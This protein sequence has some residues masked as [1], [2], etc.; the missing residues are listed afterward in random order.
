[1]RALVEQGRIEIRVWDGGGVVPMEPA[2]F[3]QM[4]NIAAL[5]IV[6]GAALMADG[7]VGVGGPVGAVV[8]T[9][10]AVVPS[11][12]GVDLGCG[13]LAVQTDLL[14][15]DLEGYLPAIRA[16]LED[17]IPVGGPGVR[18]SWAE[19]RFR[20]P[21]RVERVWGAEFDDTLPVGEGAVEVSFRVTPERFAESFGAW[22]TQRG[23][24]PGDG[25]R[26]EIAKLA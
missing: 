4:R 3:D 8:V 24:A 20:L 2:V 1:M 13:V 9:R 15:N 22:L 25:V 21:A 12:T 26:V 7:H 18:G 17:Q 11:V 14:L 10:A 16:R 19:P 6:T 5:P 23:K